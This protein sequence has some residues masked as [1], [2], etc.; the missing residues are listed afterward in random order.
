MAECK[1]IVPYTK[2]D[3]KERL[4]DEQEVLER[5]FYPKKYPILHKNNEPCFEHEVVLNGDRKYK[6]RVYVNEGYPD[7]LPDLVVCESPEPMPPWG[8]SHDTHTL[9]PKHG[10]LKIC[11]WHWAAW[12][13]EN[14]IYQVSM[15]DL[16][17]YDRHLKNQS[18]QWWR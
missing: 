16:R 13:R 10:F 15:P 9:Q 5:Y 2:P 14:M 11:H 1:A 12:K 7:M 6:L 4:E 18:V 3:L 17:A 8:G